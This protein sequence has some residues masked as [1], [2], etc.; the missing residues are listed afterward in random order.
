MKLITEMIEEIKEISTSYNKGEM[1]KETVNLQLEIM[2]VNI[3][4]LAIDF[5]HTPLDRIPEQRVKDVFNQMLYKHKYKASTYL[6]LMIQADKKVTYNKYARLV[7]QK[8]LFFTPFSNCMKRNIEGY[9][10]RN[11]FQR[12]K[13]F[14]ILIMKGNE[15]NE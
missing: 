8:D 9:T 15:S 1:D 13:P 14:Q 2:K 6:N 3:S 5:S 11:S 10:T 4:N 12:V 7:I